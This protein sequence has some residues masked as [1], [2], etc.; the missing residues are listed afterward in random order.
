M[1]TKYTVEMSR[2]IAMLVGASRAAPGLEVLTRS[3]LEA[4]SV[5]WW[6]LEDGLTARQ[7][8]CRVQLLRRN[9]AVELSRS[10]AQV[11]GDPSIGAGGESLA[12]VEAYGQQLGLVQFGKNGDELEGERRPGYTAR[13][14]AFT[15]EMGYQGGYSIYS[16]TAHAELAGLWRLF[17]APAPGSP[18]MYSVAPDQMATYMAADGALKS[19]MGAI[20]RIALLFGWSAPGRAEEVGETI[21][22]IN[23]E[24]LRLRP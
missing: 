24:L 17:P 20:E 11:G 23:R 1:A 15:D 3:S 22:H 19:M 5:V 13:V 18:P 7:R 21:E 6:L 2:C 9:S 4:A 8:V 12:A 10:I 16:S 14:K